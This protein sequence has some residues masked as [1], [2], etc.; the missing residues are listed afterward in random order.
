M[1]RVLIEDARHPGNKGG[2]V[3]LQQSPE[4]TGVNADTRPIRTAGTDSA[5]E[6]ERLKQ[7]VRRVSSLATKLLDVTTALSEAQSVE[8]VTRV[9]LTKGLAVVEAARGVLVSV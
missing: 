2:S 4:T 5:A 1:L 3:E 9:V 6:I 7:E 8:D